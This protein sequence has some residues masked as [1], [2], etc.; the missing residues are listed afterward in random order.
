[1]S[2]SVNKKERPQSSMAQRVT[3]AATL[4]NGLQ[5]K[6]L[7]E[8]QQELIQSS[9]Q[10][11]SSSLRQEEIQKSI[12]FGIR[13]LE[14][15]GEDQLKLSAESLRENKKQTQYMADQDERDKVRFLK[16]ELKEQKDA[17]IQSYK[18]ITHS[19]NREQQLIFEAKMTNLE[20]FFTL[21]K[22][23][24]VITSVDSNIFPQVSDKTYRDETEDSV[25]EK[26]AQ[27]QDELCDQD[28]VDIKTITEI[29]ELD[30]NTQASELL[31]KVDA[32][33]AVSEAIAILRRKISRKKK[34]SDSDYKDF[35]KKINQLRKEAK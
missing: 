19:I 32:E 27:I 4:Y 29:E 23:H 35:T 30:E 12:D 22:L 18:D 34:L 1:M 16:E 26:L 3:A 9:K 31:K 11:L 13:R 7:R 8:G 25:K 6:A 20:K 21:Q 10:I 5:L 24:R 2:T 28:K 15:M 33:I 17:E 14:S